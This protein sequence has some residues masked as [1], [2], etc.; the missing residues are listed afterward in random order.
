MGMPFVMVPDSPPAVALPPSG[1]LERTRDKVRLRF[2][3]DGDLRLLSHHD[4]M[5]AFE[6]MLRRAELP[7]RCTQGFNPKPRL[8]FALSLPLGVVG[9]E[10]V[11]EL[12][13]EQALPLEE[14]EQRLARQAPPG[15]AILSVRRIDFRAGAQVRSL[16][17]RLPVPDERV[18]ELRPRVARMLASAEC[19]VERTRPTP[20]RL[21]IRPF[22]RDLRVVDAPPGPGTGTA[23][24]TALDMDLWLTPGGTARP[25]EVLGL[26]EIRDLLDTGAV[27]ERTRLEL[28]DEI[29]P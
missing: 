15:L 25:D 23:C 16:C 2:R 4:L 14:I 18:P 27:L 7:F 11:V 20:R 22:L 17:Y 26:L 1:P 6:R 3:K 21:D 10:E 28:H 29:A 5:R 12:E 24:R 19:W 8:V 13:L 9:R